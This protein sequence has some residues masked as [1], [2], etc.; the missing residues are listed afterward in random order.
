M[1]TAVPPEAQ[2]TAEAVAR[3]PRTFHTRGD[4]SAYAILEQSGYFD[5]HVHVTPDLLAAVLASDASLVDDWLALSENKRTSSG[6][7]FR[8]NPTGFTVAF[9]DEAGNKVDERIYADRIEACAEFIK[10]EVEEMRQL[11]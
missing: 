2:V 10:R 4:L 3:L 1:S 9:V 5:R 8:Q 6:W 7:Y 11:G